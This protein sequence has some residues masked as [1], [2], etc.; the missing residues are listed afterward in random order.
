MGNRNTLTTKQTRELL[1]LK[2]R[3]G[4]EDLRLDVQDCD[5][6]GTNV[7]QRGYDRDYEPEPEAFRRDDIPMSCATNGNG[8]GTSHAETMSGPEM[9][10]L[11]KT[12]TEQV[13]A[14]MG[15]K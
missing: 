7:G 9:D 4:Y 8:H 14:A 10:R 1:N 12:I 13:L 2:K 3:L 15:S 5:R 6:C 11:V